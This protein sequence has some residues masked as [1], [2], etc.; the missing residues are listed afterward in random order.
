MKFVILYGPPAVG[1]L[2]TALEL[3]KITGFKV[4]HNHLSVDIVKSLYA[5]G[6]PKFWTL[7]RTIRELFIKSVSE[8]GIDTIF[9]F[10]YDAGEDDELVN[11]Y[12]SLV[13]TNGGEVLLVQLTTS[14]DVLKERVAENSRKKFQ[15]MSSP[16]SLERWLKQYKLFNQIP[17]R[18]SLTIDNTHISPQEVAL[19]IAKHFQLPISVK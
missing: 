6:E 17:E 14:P 7:V 18:Q 1:K 4:F 16:E 11:K 15:K 12:L 10:V 2:T 3:S 13:E 5:F 9:T 19:Q 8:D